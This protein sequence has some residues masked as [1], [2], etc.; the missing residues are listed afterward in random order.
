MDS[1]SQLLC[2]ANVQ[3]EAARILIWDESLGFVTGAI[4][5][6]V[7]PKTELVNVHLDRQ[8]QVPMLIYYNL[9]E[10]QRVR[11][12]SLPLAALNK[13]WD[14][15]ENGNRNGN[16]GE[17]VPTTTTTFRETP[18]ADAHR[19]AIQRARFEQRQ[20]KQRIIK[21]WIDS[22]AFDSLV[23][24]TSKTDPLLLIERLTFLLRPSSRI[25]IYSTWRELLLPSY[26]KL[27]QESEWV[28]VSLSE[29]WLR[30]YQAAPG[31]FHP[32]MNCN[33]HSGTILSATKIV[34]TEPTKKTPLAVA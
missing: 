20:A 17:G 9:S 15:D 16:E 34:S 29:S 24:V 23:I 10:S 33:G 32:S 3:A 18:G 1:L 14:E 31:R 2:L 7:S 27:R 19:T 8:M 22:A 21:N 13:D 25:I 11:L 28:D 26:S 6:K 5:S 30:P 12:Y 4:L